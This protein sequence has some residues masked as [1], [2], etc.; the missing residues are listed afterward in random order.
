MAV[1][2]GPHGIRVNTVCPTGGRELAIGP[3]SRFLGKL[4]L[5]YENPSSTALNPGMNVTRASGIH[6]TIV[7][8]L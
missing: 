5:R 2:L 1:E 6:G 3:V 7:S 4:Q 8:S